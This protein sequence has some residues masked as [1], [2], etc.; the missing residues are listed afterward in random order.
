MF[1]VNTVEDDLRAMKTGVYYSERGERIDGAYTTPVDSLLLVDM[2]Y[3]D[4]LYYEAKLKGTNDSEVQQ[5][6]ID[7]YINKHLDEIVAKYK[8]Q[9]V[10]LNRQEALSLACEAHGRNRRKRDSQVIKMIIEGKTRKEIEKEL[11]YPRSTMSNVTGRLNKDYFESLLN[12]FRDT[13]FAG[14]SEK[15]IKTF[16]E[17]GCTYKGM[18]KYLK[19]HDLTEDVTGVVTENEPE[20][21]AI[22]NQPSKGLMS[23]AKS[24]IASQDNKEEAQTKEVRAEQASF[25]SVMQHSKAFVAKEP[26]VTMEVSTSDEKEE[27]SGVSNDAKVAEDSDADKEESFDIE[28]EKAEDSSSIDTKDSSSIDTKEPSSIDTKDSSSIDTKESSSI[29]TKE[30][31]G[32]STNSSIKFNSGVLVNENGKKEEIKVLIAEKTPKKKKTYDGSVH[33][34]K[35]ASKLADNFRAAIVKQESSQKSDDV[36]MPEYANIEW[37]EKMF[38]QPED[39][40]Q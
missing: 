5:G 24:Y 6:I 37:V 36:E 18:Q 29:D 27:E 17:A 40:L 20:Q 3:F 34:G 30:H 15:S 19:H 39:T 8:K 10:E 13:V 22:N 32:V 12:E 9:K 38:A 21:N 35:W 11:G 2:Y 4:Q 1:D 14:V 28:D 16:E 31:S 23:L 7:K 25:L 33:D 26:Q